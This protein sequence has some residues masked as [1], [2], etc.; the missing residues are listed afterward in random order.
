MKEFKLIPTR[1]QKSFYGKARVILTDDGE[2]ILRSYTADVCK[3][4]KAGRFVRLWGGYS[5]TTMNHVNSFIDTYG[6]DGG[7]KKWWC[8]LPCENTEQWRVEY[9]NGFFNRTAGCRLRD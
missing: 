8:S 4:D 5:V 3:I 7:G 2:T 1:G 9:G 6:I